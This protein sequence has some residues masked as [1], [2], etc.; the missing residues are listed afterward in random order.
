MNSSKGTVKNAYHRLAKQ[1]HPDRNPNM[2][3]LHFMKIKDAYDYIT[4]FS[5]ESI[6]FEV[7]IN[8][9]K[10]D[11]YIEK[12]SPS[13]LYKDTPRLDVIRAKIEIKVVKNKLNKLKQVKDCFPIRARIERNDDKIQKFEA[14]I[15]KLNDFIARLEPNDKQQKLEAFIKSLDPRDIAKCK[16]YLTPL[17]A[18]T[19]N[20]KII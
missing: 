17:R 15:N 16:H 12:L 2:N 19:A 14:F 8:S 11:R 5:E 18:Y 20:E 6:L 13:D 4:S 10:V 1:Y 9:V 3:P 7:K